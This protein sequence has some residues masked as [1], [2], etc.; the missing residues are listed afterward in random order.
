[1]FS[2]LFFSFVSKFAAL[3]YFSIFL[4]FGVF[5]PSNG[6][7]SKGVFGAESAAKLGRNS[8]KL[9]TESA[10][11]LGLNPTSQ[12]WANGENVPN[13]GCG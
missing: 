12:F 2:A 11:K 13:R 4:F 6:A 5:E 3:S 7:A 10:V 1:M 9:G 8:S